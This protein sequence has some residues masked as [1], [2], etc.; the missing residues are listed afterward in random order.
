[1]ARRAS[2]RCR[3][4]RASC[5]RRCQH[6]RSR[7]CRMCSR[8]PRCRRRRSRSGSAARSGPCRAR[9][10][11][12]DVWSP[13]SSR[14]T[15]RSSRRTARRSRTPA[16]YD[17][18]VD[19][20]V[21][22]ATGGEPRRLTY[23]PGLDVAVAWAPDGKS[24]VFASQSYDRARPA[25]VVDG[26]RRQAGPRRSCR[27]RRATRAAY[28]P[29]GKRLAYQ[30]YP[31]WQP[32]WKHYRGGQAAQIWIADLATSHVTKVPRETVE[33]PV[34]DVERQHDL[35]RLGSRRPQGAVR[36]RPRREQG[37]RARARSRTASTSRRRRSVR[38]ASCSIGS[39]RSRSMTSRP[40]RSSRCAITIADELPQ[41]RARF[42][43]V[44]PDQI[45]HAIDLADR[46]ARADRSARRGAV[47]ARSR[48][49]TR[50]T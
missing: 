21:I 30:P 46:Q 14:T 47:G 40:S 25:A 31:L 13:D 42:M 38:V 26:A 23:H 17:G 2:P 11:P 22:A 24:I 10:A 8:F 29:D 27:C 36:V 19:V 6:R 7:R 37:E 5:R 12:R 16:C 50:A 33:R 39:A 9:A 44:G 48:R 43:P 28:S 4:C 45:L 18:N 3:R 15:G 20:Y 32:A 34:A 49:A 1:M 41:T 35:L